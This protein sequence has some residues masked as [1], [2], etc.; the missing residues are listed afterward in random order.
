[1]ADGN[2]QRCDLGCVCTEDSRVK[3]GLFC[4]CAI[5]TTPVF[6]NNGNSKTIVFL[7]WHPLNQLFKGSYSSLWS[8]IGRTCYYMNNNF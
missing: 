8:L 2:Y 3:S 6:Y 7:K 1:M 5:G 4:T